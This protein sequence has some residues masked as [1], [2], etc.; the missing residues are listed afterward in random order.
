MKNVQLTID[1]LKLQPDFRN[2]VPVYDNAFLCVYTKNKTL[3]F[4]GCA[5]LVS[6]SSHTC[7]L[8]SHRPLIP[9]LPITTT[10][11]RSR[12]PA[13]YDP[14]STIYQNVSNRFWSHYALE[15]DS[16]RDQ[17]WWAYTISQFAKTPPFI[18]PTRA[19]TMTRRGKKGLNG[20][21][22]NETSEGTATKDRRTHPPIDSCGRLTMQSKAGALP[23]DWPNAGQIIKDDDDISEVDILL[24]RTNANNNNNDVKPLER[25]WTK[26]LSKMSSLKQS[27]RI[28]DVGTDH[29]FYS[30]ILASPSL[31]SI[32]LDIFEP[33]KHHV[34]SLCESVLSKRWTSGTERRKKRTPHVYVNPYGLS[35]VEGA[36]AVYK[37]TWVRGSTNSSAT[38]TTTKVL[39]TTTLD[40]IVQERGWLEQKKLNDDT[41][42]PSHPHIYILKMDAQHMK[43][44]ALLGAKQLIEEHLAQYVFLEVSVD[45]DDDKNA[46]E[47]ALSLL[48]EAG[49]KLEGQGWNAD[50]PADRSVW[51][52]DANLAGKIVAAARGRSRDQLYLLWGL[53]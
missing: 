29:A 41:A 10:A 31:G 32:V 52:H 8:L 28:L 4:F 38:T 35:D 9:G 46:L 7:F 34:L 39:E 51:P 21:H 13:G 15:Q 6:K 23:C 16:W 25:H 19:D 43:A 53:S 26:L 49:Y 48:F 3:N 33:N 27:K 20:H 40:K 22:Y 36:S 42:S 12:T 50:G 24:G 1:H 37:D 17:P 44:K 47:S 18:I 30:S 14:A 11:P 2:E 45:G 5:M